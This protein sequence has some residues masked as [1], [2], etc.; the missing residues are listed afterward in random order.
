MQLVSALNVSIGPFSAIP[1][2]P[3]VSVS[4]RLIAVAR[5]TPTAAE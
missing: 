4:I 2:A 3:Q 5:Q 1:E